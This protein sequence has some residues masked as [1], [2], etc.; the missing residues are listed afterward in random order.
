MVSKNWKVVII[1][2]SLLKGTMLNNKNEFCQKMC[3][4]LLDCYNSTQLLINPSR[5]MVE[6]F[7]SDF[8]SV[9][10]AYATGLSLPI[11]FPL[12]GSAIV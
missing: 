11:L 6:Q 1:V 4:S 12:R 3:F 8:D 2:V 10:G 5:W 7:S 9:R